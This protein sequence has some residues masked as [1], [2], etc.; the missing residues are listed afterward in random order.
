M[1]NKMKAEKRKTT[2]TTTRKEKP[3]KEV[4]NYLTKKIQ[5][6]LTKPK[7]FKTKYNPLD[8]EASESDKYYNM[9]INLYNKLLPIY[10]EDAADIASRAKINKIVLGVGYMNDDILD[11]INLN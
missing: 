4:E 10:G 3:K 9:R 7:V 5:Y 11:E 1:T 8:Q 2:K 6:K